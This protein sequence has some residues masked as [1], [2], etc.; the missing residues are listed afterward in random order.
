MSNY[1]VRKVIVYP[2]LDD[3]DL[4]DKVFDSLEEDSGFEISPMESNIEN[5]FF[6]R[7]YYPRARWFW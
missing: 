3:N 7:I 4:W 1:W 6:S 2:L 5:Q